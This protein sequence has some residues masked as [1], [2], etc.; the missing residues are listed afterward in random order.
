MVSATPRR[1]TGRLVLMP[2]AAVARAAAFTRAA[3]VT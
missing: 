2:S 1:A 3:M